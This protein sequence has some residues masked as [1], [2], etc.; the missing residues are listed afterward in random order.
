M[1]NISQQSIDLLQSKLAVRDRFASRVAG[2]LTEDQ[3]V[4]LELSS[5]QIKDKVDYASENLKQ[6]IQYFKPAPALAEASGEIM[7]LAEEGL[8][9]LISKDIMQLNSRPKLIDSLELLVHLDGSRPSFMIKDGQ[10]DLE[11]SP[12]GDW[13][14]RISLHASEINYALSCVGRI[15]AYGMALATG[16]L[17]APDLIITN[18]HVLQKISFK[19]TGGERVLYEGATIDFGHEFLSVLSK[20]PRRLK[21]VVYYPENEIGETIIN[22]AFLDLA[23]IELYPGPGEVNT[24]PIFTNNKWIDNSIDIFVVGYPG[25]PQDKQYSITILDKLFKMTFG[26][27]RLAPGKIV[28]T[29]PSVNWSVSHDVSTLAGNS[30]SVVL[31]WNKEQFAAGLHYGGTSSATTLNWAHVLGN[32]LQARDATSGKTLEQCLTEFDVIFSQ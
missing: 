15:D 23:L 13:S 20:N 25:A 32:T 7:N 6:A 16:F 18:L 3:V 14:E 5:G 19:K 29:H 2:D 8:A 9:A 30:G 17:V 26:C 4:S 12:V 27:K 1:P 21:R 11:S 31:V 22:H 28:S 24:L 10:V